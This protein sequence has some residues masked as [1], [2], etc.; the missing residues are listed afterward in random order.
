MPIEKQPETLLVILYKLFFILINSIEICN[1]T[2]VFS[3]RYLN[4]VGISI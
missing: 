1:E 3:G 2:F 4:I